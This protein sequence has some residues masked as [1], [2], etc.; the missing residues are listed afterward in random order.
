MTRAR[1][2]DAKGLNRPDIMSRCFGEITRRDPAPDWMAA[3]RESQI[4][5]E[6]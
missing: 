6:R 1:S 4:K 3:A 2:N 5:C